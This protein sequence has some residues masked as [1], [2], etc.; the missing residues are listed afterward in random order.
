MTYKP[1]SAEKKIIRDCAQRS[2]GCRRVEIC[3][4]TKR[5]L[6]NG[7][8]AM[9]ICFISDDPDFGDTDLADNAFRWSDFTKGV[10]LTDDGR[11]TFDFYVYS[12]GRYAELQTNV[13]AYFEG[14]R[15][16]RVDGTCDGTMWRS[17]RVR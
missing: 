3:P 8:E 2:A 10:E 4:S 9:N 11:G 5:C 12:V 1:T 16:V 6:D 7:K 17:G 14:G 13:T 15:L